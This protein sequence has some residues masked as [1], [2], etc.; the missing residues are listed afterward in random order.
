MKQLFVLSICLCW[1]NTMAQIRV[2]PNHRYLQDKDGKPFFWMGDT[3]WELF[4]RMDRR[5]T[6]AYLDTRRQQGFTVIQV[7]ALAFANEADNHKPNR[8]GDFPFVDNNPDQL[9][10]T[11]GNN[12]E[13]AAQYD[14]W[15]H[16]DF[17]IQAAARMGLYVAINPVWGDHVSHHWSSKGVIFNE[18][19]ARSYGKF[20]GNRY[21]N[22]ANLIWIIGG[23][24]PTVYEKD[25]LHFD[26]RP[27]WRAMVAGIKEGEGQKRHLMSYHPKGG[28]S[29][30]G[31][32]HQENWL[33]F[34]SFQS[35]HGSRDVDAWN[36]VGR[37]LA[38]NPPKPTLDMEP[39]YEDHPINPWDGKW[40]RQRGYFNAYDIR[41]RLYRSV[42]ASMCGFTYGHHQVW[43]FLDTT[44]YA[45]LTVGD[46]LIGW[47]RALHAEAAGQLRYLKQLMLSRPYFTR[48]ADQTLIQ[49]AKGTDY[50]DLVMATRDSASTYVMVYLP[51]SKPVTIDVTRLSGD[52]KRAWWFDPRTGHIFKGKEGPMTGALTFTPPAQSNASA[53]DW[54]LI[55]DDTAQKY[56]YPGP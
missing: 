14:Y 43:Q 54:V 39:C 46:T 9:A 18:Q 36:W 27:I 1:L 6:E 53:M 15:D 3:A 56:P 32:F 37:D 4:H 55:I 21:A 25:N 38:L 7:V 16:V 41:S 29:S 40:T 30:S 13:E 28:K 44:R 26:D 51:T 49:S 31:Y 48:L 35:G 50:R 10:L 24:C 2:H 42:F 45:P 20:L 11:P 23:D 8:Y 52:K 12:P 22:Q 47:N 33:D 19:K 34:N 5:D 17:V